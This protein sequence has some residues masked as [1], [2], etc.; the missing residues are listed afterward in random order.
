M[1]IAQITHCTLNAARNPSSAYDDPIP[2]ART[3]SNGQTACTA[4]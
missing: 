4:W 3:H 2:E 1:P